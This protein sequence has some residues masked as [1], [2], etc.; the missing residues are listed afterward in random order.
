MDQYAVLGNPVNHS[1]SPAIHARFAELTHQE[2]SYTAIECPKEGFE[3][4]VKALHEQGYLGLNITVPFKL[5]AWELAESLTDRAKT[6]E[7]VNTLIRTESGWK[8]DN[9]DGVG[10]IRDIEVNAG[11]SIE[12]KRVLILGAGGAVRG[13]MSP[14]L[15]TQPSQVRIAN[16]TGAKAEALAN[17]FAKGRRVTGG[18][19]EGI[20]GQFDLIINGT[21]ASLSGELPPLSDT[22]LTSDSLCYDMMYGAKPTIFMAWAKQHGASTRDGLGMLVEQ[23]AESFKKWRGVRPDS[24]IVLEDIRHSLG[25]AD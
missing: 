19:L 2:L 4:C 24:K 6:A 18:G 5:K 16:R 8:A 12:N 1:K 17:V 22:L 3:A 21:A 20:T 10:L 25:S 7:A 9:T 23:A 14:L 11:F 13:I 15:D